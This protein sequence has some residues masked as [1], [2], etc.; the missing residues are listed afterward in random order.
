MPL[1]TDE[2]K[3]LF[4]QFD[5]VIQEAAKVMKTTCK[6]GC[7][8]C[9]KLFATCTLPEGI[10]IAEELF[11]KPDWQALVPD[12]VKAS[13]EFCFEGV[14]SMT[15]LSKKL[16]CVFLK[17]GLCSIY[18]VRP[19]V[20]RYYY[21]VQDPKLCDPDNHDRKV[22]TV[23][24]TQ[25][26]DDLNMFAIHVSVGLQNQNICAPI[27][28]MVLYA[29]FLVAG[30]KGAKRFIREATRGLPMPEDYLRAF[31]SVI[32]EPREQ[33]LKLTEEELKKLQ[34]QQG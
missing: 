26:I 23:D 18:E 22:A 27:P 10:L 34:E 15:Y 9:C 28:L 2:L 16:P 11:K 21:S 19:S 8:N 17:E 29:M 5:A 13:K 33:R 24:A 4:T 20:C 14:N 1:V 25:I 7:N 3:R 30:S 12:L 6:A 31:P 32:E